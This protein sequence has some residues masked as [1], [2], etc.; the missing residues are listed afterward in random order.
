MCE[1]FLKVSASAYQDISI[2]TEVKKIESCNTTNAL[3]L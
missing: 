3:F 1:H 2:K